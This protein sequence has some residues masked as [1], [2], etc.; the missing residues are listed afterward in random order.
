[1]LRTAAA[2]SLLLALVQAGA[3][4]AQG[5]LSGTVTSSATG[6]PV[7]GVQVSLPE[8]SRGSIS[9]ATGTYDIPNLP[10]GSHDVVFNVIGYRSVTQQVTIANG[11]TTQLD[12]TLEEEAVQLAGLV[13]V[14]SRAPPRTV[15]ESP[16]PVDVVSTTDLTSQGT[17]NLQD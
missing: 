9:G 4:T 13:V 5:T 15:T 6:T 8:L 11:E 3:L 10:A 1:M 12:V 14:G 16:V 2:A 17:V 7:A